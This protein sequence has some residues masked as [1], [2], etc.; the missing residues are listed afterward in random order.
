MSLMS[1]FGT[2]AAIE[3]GKKGGK[4]LDLFANNPKGRPIGST[5]KRTTIDVSLH[6][7]SVVSVVKSGEA[8]KKEVAVE[9]TTDKEALHKIS[10]FW[11]KITLKDAVCNILLNGDVAFN[12]H[13]ILKSNLK[14]HSVKFKS[15]ANLLDI[16]FVYF[17]REHYF[18]SIYKQPPPLLY[19]DD[20]TF[21]LKQIVSRD[22]NNNRMGQEDVV[23]LLMELSQN[24]KRKK[25]E[26][27]YYYLVRRTKF[28]G[29]KCDGR[30]VVAQPTTTNRSSITA[31]QQWR[32]YSTLEY[33]WYK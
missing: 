24:E 22:N 23:N 26:D 28:D 2:R 16:P 21:L 30:V 7:T 29:A 20:F 19:M 18:G 8:K 1:Q 25:C 3:Q 17:A 13:G 31:L 5:K 15:V 11:G 4:L 9:E 10:L 12:R 32:W 33:T 6:T 27:H 14:Y